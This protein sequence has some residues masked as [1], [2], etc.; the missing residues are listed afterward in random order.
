[1]NALRDFADDLL[2]TLTSE[3]VLKPL[4]TAAAMLALVALSFFGLTEP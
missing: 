3:G 4:A 1:M 2:E